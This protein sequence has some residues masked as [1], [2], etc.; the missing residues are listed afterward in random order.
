ME[1]ISSLV[2][3]SFFSFLY[4]LA[5]KH[6]DWVLEYVADIGFMVLGISLWATGLQL[7]QI[8]IGNTVAYN[9]SLTNTTMTYSYVDVMKTIPA[10]NI[11]GFIFLMSGVVLI[12]LTWRSMLKIRD[13]G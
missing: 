5:R 10:A 11:V 9:T 2:L 1:L 12:M 3:L 6:E 4:A 13:S 8:V 7:Y